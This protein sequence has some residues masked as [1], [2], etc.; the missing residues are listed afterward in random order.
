MTLKKCTKVLLHIGRR[1]YPD[2]NIHREIL[3]EKGMTDG[4]ID[5][6]VALPHGYRKG[7]AVA[8]VEIGDTALVDE[9]ERCHEMIEQNVIARGDVMGRY[10][11]TI[12][13]VRWLK[14]GGY[15]VKGAPGIWNVDIPIRYLPDSEK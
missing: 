9:K 8:L 5:E 2:G 6:C 14:D 15:E 13:D 12:T 1:T 7:Q 4:E 11:T 10:L 3:K